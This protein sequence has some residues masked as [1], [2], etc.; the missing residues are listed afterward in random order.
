MWQAL[1]S[2]LQTGLFRYRLAQRPKIATR[3]LAVEKM[4]RARQWDLVLGW[5]DDGREEKNVGLL[6]NQKLS[7]KFHTDD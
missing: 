3:S 4:E 6:I 2:C 5:E 7:L 1:K